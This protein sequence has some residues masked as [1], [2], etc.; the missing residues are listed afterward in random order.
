MNALWLVDDRLLSWFERFSRWFQRLTGRT[1]FF[2][3][4]LLD[5]ANSAVC[6]ALGFWTL[7]TTYFFFSLFFLMYSIGNQYREKHALDAASRG[8]ANPMKAIRW[9]KVARIFSPFLGLWLLAFYWDG[10]MTVNQT[11]SIVVMALVWTAMYFEACDPLPP[12]QSKIRMWL[13][14]MKAALASQ[15]VPVRIPA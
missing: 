2:L 4:A 7:N 5:L 10:F 15:P 3:A 9:F 8:F 12:S 13:N 6:I 11:A 14:S 1:N